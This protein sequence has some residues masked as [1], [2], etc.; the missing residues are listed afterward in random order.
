M[1]SLEWKSGYAAERFVVDVN[2]R[3][4]EDPREV[5]DDRMIKTGD[6]LKVNRC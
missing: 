6:T 1:N 4:R 2:H 5:I 3:H